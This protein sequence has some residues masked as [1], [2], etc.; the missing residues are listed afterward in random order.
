MLRAP[1]LL[2]AV[3]TAY[4]A[5]PVFQ[6]SFDNGQQT[7]AVDRGSAALDSAV[8]HEGHKSIRLE[9]GT[10]PDACVR[11]AP[12]ALTI[13]KR[14]ELTGWIRTEDLEVRDLDRTPIA[15]GAA[16]AMTSMPFDVHSASLGGT[17]AW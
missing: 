9:A 8:L 12:V 5:T 13:G 1:I 16:L 3:A 15:V 7:W 4:A 14:Y 10:S 17:Q 11:L 2:F 6:G